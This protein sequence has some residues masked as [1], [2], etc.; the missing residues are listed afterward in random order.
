MRGDVEDYSYAKKEKFL[1][2]FVFSFTYMVDKKKHKETNKKA[3][4]GL[5]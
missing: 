2:W 4:Y 5:W 3:C 1:T